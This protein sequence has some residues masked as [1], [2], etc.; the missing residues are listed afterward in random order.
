MSIREYETFV[1]LNNCGVLLMKQQCYDAAVKTFLDAMK[2]LN[3][4]FVVGCQDVDETSDNL[5]RDTDFKSMLTTAKCRLSEANILERPIPVKTCD[6]TSFSGSIRSIRLDINDYDVFYF[7]EE[8][9]RD[10]AAAMIVFNLGISYMCLSHYRRIHVLSAVL[11]EKAIHL[12][13]LSSDLLKEKFE[14]LEMTHIPNDIII[15]AITVLSTLVNVA[16]SRYDVFLEDIGHFEM[17]IALMESL[18][19]HENQIS[20]VGTFPASAA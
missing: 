4:L 20:V 11:E 3:T 5:S 8:E 2:A 12:F 7:R 15:C 1:Y 13:G 16:R 14:D 6:D 17:R 10:L 18:Y 9:D 19:R